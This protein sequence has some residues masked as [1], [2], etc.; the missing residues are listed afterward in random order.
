M[1]TARKLEKFLPLYEEAIRAA[2]PNACHNLW[3]LY[4]NAW[5]YQGDYNKA[6]YYMHKMDIISGGENA[7]RYHETRA[8]VYMGQKRYADALD[9]ELNAA[10][11]EIRTRYE[12]DKLEY[13]KKRAMDKIQRNRIYFLFASGG[14]VLLTFALCIWIYYSRAIVR[15]NRGLYR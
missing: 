6:K 15:K 14:C 4:T 1:E 10:L 8:H 13:E 7:D 3:L 2:Q 12:V 9:A 5:R 11:D